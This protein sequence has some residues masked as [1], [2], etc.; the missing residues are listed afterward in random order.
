MFVRLV[1]P[2]CVCVCWDG[3]IQQDWDREIHLYL[4]YSNRVSYLI[5]ID[6]MWVSE[7][8]QAVVIPALEHLLTKKLRIKMGVKFICSGWGRKDQ[9]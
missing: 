8:R 3:R 5:L 7:Q 4:Y 2:H 9:T 6:Q 1:M